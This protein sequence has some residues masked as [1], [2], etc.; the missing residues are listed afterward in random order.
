MYIR[1]GQL[2]DIPEI[3]RVIE[4]GRKYMRDCGNTVQWSNGY[5]SEEQIA[6]EINKE[7]FFVWC[8]EEKCEGEK[9]TKES[10]HGVFSFII[11]KDPTYD[12][13]EG[14]KWLNNDPYGTIHRMANDG[15]FGGMFKECLEFCKGKVG[16]IRMD[17]HEINI[18]MRRLAVD[19]GFTECGIIYV[20][21]GTP[22]VAYQLIV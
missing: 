2:K 20:A 1:K 22:R 21:D 6:N 9:E 8:C 19:C 3:M 5:P 11:G 14:G 17:T 13:I 16:N 12:R 18:H 4:I 10:I 7:Q 15:T